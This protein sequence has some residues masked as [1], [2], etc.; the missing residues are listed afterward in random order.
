MQLLVYLA[1]DLKCSI[2]TNDDFTD[3]NFPAQGGPNTPERPCEILLTQY[4][5]ACEADRQRLFRDVIISV[6]E[7]M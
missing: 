2:N 1:R 6:L 5:N 7:K 4:T 3:N